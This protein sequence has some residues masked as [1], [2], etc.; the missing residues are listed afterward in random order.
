MQPESAS[1]RLFHLLARYAYLQELVEHRKVLVL[2][3]ADEALADA[4]DR[5]GISRAL[6][7]DPS[8]ERVE[9]ARRESSNRRVDFESGVLSRLRLREGA[10]DVAIVD[11]FANL[12]DRAR[13][14]RAIRRMLGPSGL[15]IASTK[16]PDAAGGLTGSSPQH[17]SYYEF[18]GQLADSF[19]HVRMV[20][21][22]PLVGFTLADL[23]VDSPET[24]ITFDSSL[25]PEGS[26]DAEFFIAF[27]SSTLLEP[28]PFAV[29]Q[30]PLD[31]IPFAGSG[32]RT[33]DDSQHQAETIADP[34][35]IERFER[36][37]ADQAAESEK[38]ISQLKLE[39]DR[40]AVNIAKLENHLRE[41]REKASLEHN[42][43]VQTKL[44]LE[45]ERKKFLSYTK[46][47]EM[48]RRL[49]VME[50]ADQK[51]LEALATQ[52]E[53]LEQRIE[54]V[55]ET[56][57]YFEGRALGFAV[58]LAEERTVSEGLAHR[59]ET[60]AT[61]LE[62]LHRAS[63]NLEELQN[64]LAEERRAREEAEARLLESSGDNPDL[65][66][67]LARE[68]AER[69]LA[70]TRAAELQQRLKHALT[71]GP[72][73]TP[74]QQ[75]LRKAESMFGGKGDSGEEI[76]RLKAALG[77]E[78]EAREE[79]E[80]RL[81]LTDG[82]GGGAKLEAEMVKE[83]ELRKEAE[84][85]VAQ[86]EDKLSQSEAVATRLSMEGS[87]RQ[88]A[89]A[90]FGTIDRAPQ[91]ARAA[92]I[93]LSRERRARQKA[94]A[95]LTQL[96]GER[97]SGSNLTAALQKSEAE[98]GE[99]AT[100]LAALQERLE[101]ADELKVQLERAISER[102]RAIGESAR[103]RDRLAKQA[104]TEAARAVE[105]VS[106]ASPSSDVVEERASRKQAEEALFLLERSQIE[107]ISQLE[108]TV[109]ER[110]RQVSDLESER[111][112][113]ADLLAQVLSELQVAQTAVPNLTNE[114][115]RREGEL[116]ELRQ[117]LRLAEREVAEV[118]SQ[119]GA[120]DRELADFAGEIQGLK[121]KIAEGS[122]SEDTQ[123]DLP[124]LSTPPIP[125]FPKPKGGDAASQEVARAQGKAEVLEREREL[126][127]TELRAVRDELSQVVAKAARAEAELESSRN[128]SAHLE[129]TVRALRESLQGA[130]NAASEST[131]KLALLDRELGELKVETKR[132]REQIGSLNALRKELQNRC[133]GLEQALST[134]REEANAATRDLVSAQACMAMLE[135]QLPGVT[136]SLGEP[137]EL[138]LG[139]KS[140]SRDPG[141]ETQVG[142]FGGTV[143]RLR[144]DSAVENKDPSSEMGASP[145]VRDLEQKLTSSNER[146]AALRE[147]LSRTKIQATRARED[148]EEARA[149]VTALKHEMKSLESQLHSAKE[150]TNSALAESAK[151]GNKLGLA[152]ERV[153]L[154]EGELENKAQRESTLQDRL[155]GAARSQSEAQEELRRVRE[156]Y[157]ELKRDHEQL[158]TAAQTPVAAEPISE[159]E[160]AE[161]EST[162]HLLQTARAELE[163]QQG[164]RAG[165]TFRISELERALD[166]R[167][168]PEAAA[169][170]ENLSA[171]LA[172][173]SEAVEQHKARIEELAQQAEAAAAHAESLRFIDGYREEWA[174]KFERAE[175]EGESLRFELDRA[176]TELARMITVRAQ[177]DDAQRELAERKSQILELEEEKAAADEALERLV[178]RFSSASGDA[179]VL[180]ELLT[181]RDEV[182]E[183]L[184]SK[185]TTTPEAE[186]EACEP[187]KE[188]EPKAEPEAEPEAEPVKES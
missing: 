119:L 27:C 158:A 89:E 148:L 175:H 25:L 132:T 112:R 163:R 141:R 24:S 84:E 19:R 179:V 69:K 8:A 157:D 40:R 104:E 118:A 30:V 156:R 113:Q 57:A 66:A 22:C 160:R 1:A 90:V 7:I 106:G 99:L 188:P 93:E 18:Y 37:L 67:E 91:P 98:K 70:E 72:R 111:S 165:L 78:Q 129:E 60:L 147:E 56:A 153:G 149:R 74:V 79:A 177:L 102:K 128:R 32:G 181:N 77:R 17:L 110:D 176:R 187:E 46:D 20:G 82:S 121:W 116:V 122:T 154:L 127:R 185:L 178:D 75:A 2:G 115:E 54:G 59:V 16:N 35:Q 4:L 126:A 86:L 145:A 180:T 135:E 65:E 173:A 146:A 49:Q 139:D 167:P 26:E 55:E 88:R 182:I 166:E 186:D 44:A 150:R 53:S 43:V 61:E 130:E 114:L 6:I 134:S 95:E 155:K 76:A 33:T 13:E 142:G 100:R 36:K 151:L 21:Q 96:K 12:A 64:A 41:A 184:Q 29:V 63:S 161:L 3:K 62:R 85:K 39:I 143:I 117:R 10:F 97:V 170:S 68:R 83:R 14:L 159:G 131:G 11:D 105:I 137:V 81:S 34:K 15:L 73:M 140:T 50:P 144:A 124:A 107:E 108:A 80:R 171:E 38:E 58:R 164:E 172:A 71:A 9:R 52:K 94:Q 28:D 92:E 125:P 168:A 5:Q 48:D 152:K 162:A 169:E 101:E 123:D 47:V 136:E 103:L 31:W 42:R 109:R 174:E 45:A 120:R 133:D 138:S 23:A 183:K 51:T 87:A